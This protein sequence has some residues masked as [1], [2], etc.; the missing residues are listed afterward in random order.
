MFD[1]A[2]LHHSPSYGQGT[3]TICQRGPRPE[4]AAAKVTALG[5]NELSAISC[6]Q[7]AQSRR[8]GCTRLKTAE[9][10]SKDPG[11]EASA[12]SGISEFEQHHQQELQSR[13]DAHK[14][15]Q[16]TSCWLE[17]QALMVALK[18]ISSLFKSESAADCRD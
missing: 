7:P 10:L 11:H 1:I 12:S 13:L 9:G 4:I 6:S 18:E 16:R 15:L 8:Q 2:I 5:C 3:R 17:P 14:C